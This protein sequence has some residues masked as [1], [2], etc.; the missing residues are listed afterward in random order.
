MGR[1][2]LPFL[3]FV[4]CAALASAVPAEA[5]EGRAFW[6]TRWNARS[7]AA[8]V[9][10]LEGMAAINANVLFCQ[11]YGDAMALHRS[12][13][14]PRSPLV[15]GDF[16]ALAVAIEEG[17]RRGIEV[18]AWINVLNVYSGGLAPPA[19]PAHIVNAH[20]EWAVVDADGRSDLASLGTA[21]TLIFFCPEWEGFHA[22]STDVAA[23]IAAGYDADGIHLDYLRFPGGPPRCFCTEHRR[24]F[25]ARYGRAP[26]DADPDFIEQR[27]ATITSLFAGIYDAVS[28]LRPRLKVSAAL[29]AP[30]GRYFQDARRILESGK[31][32]I[33]VPMI[34]TANTPLFEERAR[35]FREHSGGRLVYGGIDV[36]GGQSGPQIEAA[37]RLGLQGQSFFSW[38]TLDAA[39][40][41]DIAA[42]YA[43]SA[44]TPSMPWKD[45]SA[46]TTPPLISALIASGILPNEA[47]ILLHTDER[48]RARADYGTTTARGTLTPPGVLAFDHA[49][50]LSGLEPATTYH[51]RVIV[52]DEAGN[53]A[54]SSAASFRTTAGGPVEVIVDDRDDGFTQGGPWS[55]GSS[56]GGN[57]GDYLFSSRQAQETA[58][59]R[60]QPYLPRAGRYEVAVWYVA[61]TNRVSDAP[62]TVVHA[63][64]NQTFAVN[65]KSGGQSWNALGT[66]RFREGS[67]GY[68]RLSNQASG[69]D[70][71]IADAVR[72]RLVAPETP[73][74]RGDANADL[75][76]D[77]SDAVA[78]L[79]YLF[80]GRRAPPC[81]DA[82][83]ADDNG[84]VNVADAVLIL[85]HI[86]RGGR[87]PPPPYPAP[88]SDPTPDALASC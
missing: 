34:Y 75:I 44:P 51:Y 67:E 35:W 76:V 22:Y 70:V 25:T 53:R 33:A 37:R 59:A 72:F 87:P 19:S 9:S 82:A 42:K 71:V 52:E 43:S 68:V 83:D 56:P 13:F 27:F 40:R 48:S 14:V 28:A 86:F 77:I 46:D 57:G 15:S 38:S 11:V 30:S 18:H 39:G 85:E 74:V 12:S 26:A 62:Y 64:G 32:D 21:G 20:P 8:I 29:V 2:R 47:T 54:F 55:S 58:W 65:Q 31:L 36:A 7:R 6:L 84:A 4:A 45:G 79:A 80:A 49:V 69:G 73:F 23:E 78:I 5:A 50:R 60:F 10:C 16:D 66:F 63:D 61:G 81:L 88:G 3:I 24:R 17:R 41:S 1:A